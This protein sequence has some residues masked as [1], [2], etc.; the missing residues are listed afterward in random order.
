MGAPLMT[1]AAEGLPEGLL[2]QAGEDLRLLVKGGRF[3]SADGEN[4]LNFVFDRAIHDIPWPRARWIEQLC[5]NGTGHY[6]AE[7]RS[8][9][10]GHRDPVFS[11]YEILGTRGGARVRVR[12]LLRGGEFDL[13]DAGLSVTARSDRMLAT[14]VISMEGIH[15]TAGIG[16]PFSPKHGKELVENFRWLYGQKKDQMKWEEMM[17][18]YASRIYLEYKRHG[19]RIF[20]L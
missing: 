19:E 18:R 12:D 11:I 7:E 10:A 9:L 4:D 2:L 3:L 20:F 15:F 6:S 5:D 1:R 13:M 8:F 16:M 17:R 14:R